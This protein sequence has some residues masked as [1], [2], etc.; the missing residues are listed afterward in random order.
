M[1]SPPPTHPSL[2]FGTPEN[3]IATPTSPNGPALSNGIGNS[4]LNDQGILVDGTQGTDGT[5]SI[6]CFRGMRDISTH[7]FFLKAQH[8][9]V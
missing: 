3:V 1:P 9:L 4:K 7:S 6:I 2:L 8:R 5:F